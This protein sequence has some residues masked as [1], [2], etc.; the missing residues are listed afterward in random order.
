M[1][2]T[3][4]ELY[5]VKSEGISII[6]IQGQT[7]RGGG[8][9]RIDLYGFVACI[10]MYVYV[11]HMQKHRPVHTGQVMADWHEVGDIADGDHGRGRRLV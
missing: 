2:Q 6:I 8:G 10:I 1:V 4:G 3:F 9:R 7:R 11:L 5:I